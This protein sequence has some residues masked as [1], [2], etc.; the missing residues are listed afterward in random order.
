MRGREHRIPGPAIV[1][2][3][4][5]RL[6]VDRRQLPPLE[7]IGRA[8]RQTFLLPLL[9]DRQPILVEQEAVVSEEALEDR[10]VFRKRPYCS[11]VQ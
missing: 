7:R 5:A 9:I 1:G 4:L 8:F 2:V 11:F 10:R 3:V 6:E